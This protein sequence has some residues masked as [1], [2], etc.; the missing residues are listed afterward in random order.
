MICLCLFFERSIEFTQVNFKKHTMGATSGRKFEI[1]IFARSVLIPSPSKAI[2]FRVLGKYILSGSHFRLLERIRSLD[3]HRSF[4]YSE[5][6]NLSK[7]YYRLLE[8]ISKAR[9]L[10]KFRPLREEKHIGSILSS[11]LVKA[12]LS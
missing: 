1:Y 6:M 3:T 11:S 4:E 12:N 2:E 10:S 5:R 9:N 7:T 8:C